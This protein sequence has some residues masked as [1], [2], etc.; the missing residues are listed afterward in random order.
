[1]FDGEELD[2][3]IVRTFLYFTPHVLPQAALVACLSGHYLTVIGSTLSRA[4]TSPGNGTTFFHV[5]FF[6]S[7]FH[8]SIAE[9]IFRNVF[10]SPVLSVPVLLENARPLPIWE[11]SILRRVLFTFKI[12]NM[13]LFVT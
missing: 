10:P 9:L 12:C 5:I 2:R 3:P 8:F 1:M 4:V 7:V 11:Q 6:F 13:G